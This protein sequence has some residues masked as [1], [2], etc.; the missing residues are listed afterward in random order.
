M[1][2]LP[3]Y[4]YETH[5]QSN[6]VLS[7]TFVFGMQQCHMCLPCTYMPCK[8]C[9]GTEKSDAIK[10]FFKFFLPFLFV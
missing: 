4:M 6:C 10:Y 5:S 8:L 3:N 1:A 2:Q 7:L 9:H